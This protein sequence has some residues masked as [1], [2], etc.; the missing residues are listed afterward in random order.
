[1]MPNNSDAKSAIGELFGHM[2]LSRI[3]WVDDRHNPTPV[4]EVIPIVIE[5]KSK[6]VEKAPQL[7]GLPFDDPDE[8]IVESLRDLWVTFDPSIQ[9]S[10]FGSLGLQP[11]DNDI[12]FSSAL[13]Q[14]LDNHK[15]E[16]LSPDA[17]RTAK[18][19]IF[20]DVAGGNVLLLF[21]QDLSG[22]GG[23]T[24]EGFQLILEVLEQGQNSR[25]FCGLLS[26]TFGPDEVW[27]KQEL[28]SRGL[29]P[30]KRGRFVLISKQDLQGD[31]PLR[32]AAM[33]KLTVLNESCRDLKSRVTKI[34]ER[35]VSDA[36]TQVDN[37]SIYA[38]DEIVF[39]SS[40]VEGVWE[41]DT[42]LR[43]FSVFLREAM[44]GTARGD[45]D[46]RVLANKI[47]NVSSLPVHPIGIS[48][49]DVVD[50]QWMEM[51]ENLEH[52]NSRHLPLELGDIFASSTTGK[53]YILLN[54]PC[55]LM[56]REAKLKQQDKPGK[57]YF[58]VEQAVLA[59]IKSELPANLRAPAFDGYFELPF[60]DRK[61]HRYVALRLIHVVPIQI[62][63]LCV[64]NSDGAATWSVGSPCPDDL[65]PSWQKRHAILEKMITASMKVYEE[66]AK[67][68]LPAQDQVQLALRDFGYCR[69]FR[70]EI[71]SDKNFV[72]Y[73]CK[74]VGRLRQ[75]RAGA[76]LT[77]YSNFVSR[78]AFD[79]E[80]VRELET[81][82]AE[83]PTP[84]SLAPDAVDQESALPPTAA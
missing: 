71:T 31:Q 7:T 36:A 4:E 5:Q 40:H 50:I 44:L 75:P 51:Y 52:L 25:L 66:K 30:A 27:E 43:L 74:R 29:D 61:A 60:L 81:P 3:I 73:D 79:H 76:L 11:D 83:Q 38:F 41:P 2:A 34:I 49:T 67:Y 77:R 9:S 1:M 39:R 14:L 21:D 59:E 47:R 45:D 24:E 10:I 16:K 22:A 37:I 17:W 6:L 32:F 62:L 65:I 28:F 68:Q 13:D 23:G 12:A 42:L 80:F 26:N 55:D 46:L 54:Q 78:A 82:I 33:L 48:K 18:A 64:Y 58:S 19:A 72:K 57:R 70:G 35:A 63:D 69:E 8:I 15:P 56:V 53:T 84:P 20:S